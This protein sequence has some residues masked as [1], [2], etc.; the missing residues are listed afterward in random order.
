MNVREL[1]EY[2]RGQRNGARLSLRKMSGLAGVSIP[3]LSQIERGLRKPSAEVLQGIAKGLRISAEQ[4]YVK[5]GILEA[6]PARDVAAAIMDDLT[7]TERQKQ[8]LIQIYEAF[9]EET[10]RAEPDATASSRPK[11]SGTRRSAA[12]KP[13]APRV[14][15]R[16]GRKPTARAT[17]ETSARRAGTRAAKGAS[18]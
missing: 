18:S 4:L 11:T 2:I 13:G 10:G 14:A 6:R 12:G 3:Y 8:A 17:T 7:I 9:R 5:A 16:S 15:A 1:G